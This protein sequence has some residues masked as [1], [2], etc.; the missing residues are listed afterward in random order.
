MQ[1]SLQG[2]LAYHLVNSVILTAIVSMFVLWRYRV[3]VL[4]GMAAGDEQVVPVPDVRP[5]AASPAAPF[6]S[7]ALKWQRRREWRLALSY[8]LATL[9][10]SLPLSLGGFYLLD[11]RAMY[12]SRVLMMALL[13]A[14]VCAPMIAAA[15]SLSPARALKGVVVLIAVLTSAVVVGEVL[16][17]LVLGQPI[18]AAQ[19]AIALGFLGLFPTQMGLLGLFWL[20]TWP[21]KL[22]GVAPLTFA[23]LVLFGLAPFSAQQLT[24]I[25]STPNA[26][27]QLN[28]TFLFVAL[29]AGCLGWMRLRQLAAQYER[30][31][32]SDTQLLSRSWWLMLMMTVGLSLSTAQHPWAAVVICAF[33][34]LGFAPV[35]AWLLARRRPDS[36][37]PEA[38]GGR[39]LLLLRTFGYTART[40]RLF[41]HIGARWR[42]FGPVFLIAAPDVT[43][44]TIG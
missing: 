18:G 38:R 10:S 19:L 29:P 36:P 34:L 32:F 35:S 6:V 15:L 23:A 16:E 43:A 1:T 41:D 13:Y 5:P 20:A 24:A 9:L 26:T 30:K 2:D 21:R 31:R 12:P 33:S 17:D 11:V 3:S 44:R 37:V 7:H 8:F 4:A 27:L 42:S 14:S 28:A 39:T 25:S 40:E 22:R